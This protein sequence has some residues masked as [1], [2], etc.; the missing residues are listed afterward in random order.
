[1]ARIRELGASDVPQATEILAQGDPCTSAGGSVEKVTKTLTSALGRGSVYVV[2]E[3]SK[4]I[5][6]T[7]FVSEP[8]LA[9]GGCVRF[10]AVHP[11]KRRRGIGRQLM[12]FVERKV[13]SHSSNVF[14]SVSSL[15]EAAQQFFA[16]LGYLKIGEVSDEP[17]A[18]ANEWILRKPKGNERH[19]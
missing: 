11:E 8:I 9:A 3:D 15:N 2:E 6:I 5:G 16:E 1:M 10:I 17:A 18:G 4:L 19:R 13:F 12:G 7:C 14:V